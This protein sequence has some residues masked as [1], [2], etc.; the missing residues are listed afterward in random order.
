MESPLAVVPVSTPFAVKRNFAYE[1]PPM[2]L[3]VIR[4]KTK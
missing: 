4:I 3:T 1:A 2:S